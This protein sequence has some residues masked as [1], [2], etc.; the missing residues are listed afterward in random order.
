[1]RL[2]MIPAVGRDPGPVFIRAFHRA[3]NLLKTQ[4]P[5]K[6]FRA[7]SHFAYKTALQLTAA[8]A[9]I[10][11]QQVYGGL[12]SATDDPRDSAPQ[13]GSPFF[14]RVHAIDKQGFN[15]TDLLRQI[16]S[17]ISLSG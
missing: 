7:E 4:N 11:S 16:V 15:N 12:T 3:K 2:I 5:A 13:R 9:H 17:I 14:S 6:Q 1:M 8:D 10:A